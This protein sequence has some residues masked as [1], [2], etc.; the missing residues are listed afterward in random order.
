MK[1]ADISAERD[2]DG[3]WTVAK[4]VFRGTVNG[5]VLLVRINNIKNIFPLEAI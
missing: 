5:T 2:T 3:Q 1:C 4:A